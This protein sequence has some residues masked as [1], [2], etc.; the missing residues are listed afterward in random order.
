V[1]TLPR[2][3]TE[4]DF[5][6]AL[7]KFAAALGEDQ[8]VTADEDVALYRDAYSPLWNEPGEL[9]ASAAVVPTTVE[10]VQAIVRIANEH[11]IPLYPIATGKNLGYGGSA[12]NLS[13]SV[14]VDLKRM[15]RIL[16]VDDR[17]GFALVE[18]GVSYFDLYRHIEERGLKVWIDCPDPGWGSPVGNALDHGVG[19]TFGPFRDHFGSHCGMEVVL[20]NGELLRTGMGALPKA[21]SWQEYRYGFGPYVDGLFGQGNFGIVT[22]MGFWLMPQPEAYR[23]GLVLVPR[24]RDLIA[25]VDQVNYLEHASLIGQPNYGCPLQRL[26]PTEPELRAL[27][28]KP[29]GPT[30]DELDR[31]AASH[32]SAVWQCELQFYG[33]ARTVEVN[34]EHAQERIAAAI[35]GARFEERESYRFPLSA[36]DKEGVPHKVALG[37]PNMAIFSIGARTEANPNPRDGHLWFAPVIPKSG[38]AILECQRVL[39]EVYRELGLGGSAFLQTPATWHFRTFIML[40]GFSISRTDPAVNQRSLANF[41]RVVEVAAEHGWGEYRSPPVM[42]DKIMSTYSFGDHALRRFCETLKDAADPN[43]IIAAGRSGIWPRYLRET[44]R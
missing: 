12:P 18:P 36:E 43:G 2:G 6:A 26:V 44:S 13:G 20:P 9:V 31:F 23:A 42:A 10:Q 37:I 15:N 33:P 14:V 11:R 30:D 41:R 38:E 4:T 25:L 35:Q 24:R 3:L 22:K 39:G 40:V 16:E 7:D 5:R 1:A 21:Q 27:L 28:E 8:V 17:R 34:W 32:S 29:G 19:Y